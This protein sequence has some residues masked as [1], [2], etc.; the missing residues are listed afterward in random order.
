MG[1]GVVSFRCKKKERRVSKLVDGSGNNE[2]TTYDLPPIPQKF[3]DNLIQHLCR[4][5]HGSMRG[6]VIGV[7]FVKLKNQ[8]MTVAL[9]N[10]IPAYSR[11]KKKSEIKNV[12]Q[13][14]QSSTPLHIQITSE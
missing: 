1:N 10:L 14:H 13:R 4:N 3:R 9:V 12:Q 7:W 8:G 5:A 2:N 6:R 11:K